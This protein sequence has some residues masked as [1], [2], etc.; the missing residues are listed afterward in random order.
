MSTARTRPLTSPRTTVRV[1]AVAQTLGAAVLA[2]Y[3]HRAT[4]IIGRD[5]RLVPPAWIVRVLGM[6]S[7]VQGA[8]EFRWPTPAL[9]WTGATVDATHAATMAFVATRSRRYRRAA[10]VSG[11]FATLSAAGQAAAAGRELRSRSDGERPA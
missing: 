11:V 2:A 5:Q 10:F 1:L 7:L 8:A 4:R 3:P 9:A 6:R